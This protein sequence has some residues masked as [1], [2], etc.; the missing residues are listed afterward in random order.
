[1]CHYSLVAQIFSPGRFFILINILFYLFQFCCFFPFLLI[2]IRN[3]LE[4]ATWEFAKEPIVDKSADQQPLTHIPL[5]P[6]HQE[7]KLRTIESTSCCLILLKQH[8]SSETNFLQ[9]IKMSI[10]TL[11]RQMSNSALLCNLHRNHEIYL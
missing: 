3:S 10:I 6:I 5:L 1:M 7:A 9:K 2:R 11:H 8:I 4:S